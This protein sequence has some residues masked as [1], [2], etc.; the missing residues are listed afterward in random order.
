MSIDWVG[1]AD[2]LKLE[3][4][5]FI[6]GRYTAVGGQ[7][8][9]KYS[10]RDGRL[11]CSFGAGHTRD[12]DDAV[13]AAR[14]A[15]D[16]GR[17]SKL[18]VQ[19]R[20]DVLFKLIASIEQHREELALLE[21]LD[22]GK[23]IADALNLDVT[24]AIGTLKYN[25]EAADKFHGKVYAAD[26]TSLS[27]QLRRP[28]GVVGA[29]IGWNFP[30]VLAAGKIGPALAT[31][32]S[33]VLKPSEF[34]SLSAARIAELALEA[35]VP[36]GVFNVVHGA[37]AVGAAIA[38]HRDID[39]I[40]FTGST[41]TGKQLLIAS[42]QS[43]M[44]RLILEC[45]GKAPNIVFDDAPDLEAVADA[46]VMRAFFNQGQVC[47]ASSRLLIQDSI[48]SQLLPLII[49]KVQMLTPGDPLK[50]ETKFGAVMSHEHRHKVMGYI[51][52]GKR[53]GARIVYESDGPPPFERGAYVAPVIFDRVLP[54]QKI[55][56]EEIFGPVLSVLSFRDE[57]EAV[58]IANDTIYGLSAILWTKDLGRAHRVT[59]GINAGWIVVNATG[60]PVGGPGRGIVSL[61][62]HKESGHGIEAGIE[63]L[64]EYMSQTT[65]QYFV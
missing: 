44:K 54:G 38:Q 28:R 50:L 58:R 27:Y 4:R 6:D 43:N 3:V 20:K 8:L 30:L 32:N 35:G 62:G 47:S 45:G 34:T 13:A 16:D 23:P 21:C 42:G 55:A 9:E 25:A 1:R 46:V 51:E 61:G 15:F 10:S 26:S 40:T 5:N 24:M 19:R 56:Q 18:P 14:R 57:D 31:G 60:K 29:V 33:L 37:G 64:E 63:G 11:L 22:V 65:V 12:V 48:Q 41:A 59:Q 49:R 36:E 52:S 2:D 17:W 39:L 53:E 7:P